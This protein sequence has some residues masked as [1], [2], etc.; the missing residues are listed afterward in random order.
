MQYSTDKV[1]GQNFSGANQ[2]AMK[3]IL[4]IL[5]L[6]ICPLFLISGCGAPTTYERTEILM[7]T[8]VTL[9]AEGKISQAAVE[10]SFEKIFEPEKNI[11]AD[12]KK[13]E[14]AAS[15]AYVKISPD[16]YK[17][18]ETAQKFS[19]LTDGA[20]DVTIGAAARLILINVA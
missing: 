4:L 9:K 16:V 5:S 3:K 1:A 7:G 12:V 14:D 17:I 18:L 19:E 10:E 6:F 2:S 8:V 20:F 13:I 11:S 15:V